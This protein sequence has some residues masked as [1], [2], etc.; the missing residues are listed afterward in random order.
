MYEVRCTMYAW[1]NGNVCRAENV[2]S[3]MWD[4]RPYLM[5]MC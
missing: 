5:E 1:L 4:V 3:T 2:R